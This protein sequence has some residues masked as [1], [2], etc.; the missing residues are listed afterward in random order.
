M[1]KLFL[2]IALLSSTVVT[3]AQEVNLVTYQ[4]LNK[5]V[6]SK[7][8]DK[9][10]IINFWATWCGPCIKEIPYFE[11]AGKKD[12]IDVYLVSLDFP[13]ELQKVKKFVVKKG[14][15]SRIMLMNEK[16]YDAYI[17]KINLEWSG[18]IPATLFIDSSGNQYFHEG[19]F[20]R[21]ELLE[22]I[23]KYSD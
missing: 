15:K 21:S 19:E 6:I 2:L 14:L 17:R 22:A 3:L 8:S 10:Q 4:Q 5:E 13:D 12:G 11:E 7:S 16:D 1:Q 18:A 9:L 20:N 23:N